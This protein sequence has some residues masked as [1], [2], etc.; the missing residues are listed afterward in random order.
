MKNKFNLCFRIP[1]FVFLILFL[2]GC[3]N[4]KSEITHG[5]I[6][7]DDIG[8]Q[9]SIQKVPHK[10]V[11]LAPN[12]TEIIF[13]LHAENQ[14]S[15]VSDYCNYPEGVKQKTKIGGIINPNLEAIVTL[16]PDLVFA[17]A[18]GN[19]KPTVEK[20]N[21]LNIPVFTFNTNNMSQLFECI[22]TIG[23]I[24]DHSKEADSIVFSMIQ[25]LTH[26]NKIEKQ[27][28]VF[29]VLNRVPII[30]VS[31]GSF[32]NEILNLAGGRNA[33]PEM[34][35]RYPT[36]NREEVLNLNPDFIVI[37]EKEY[38]PLPEKEYSDFE[39]IATV[40]AYKNKKIY[41]VNPDLILRPGPRLV[42]GI[43][44]LNTILSQ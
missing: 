36:I 33:V 20:L 43:I 24:T 42:Q 22:K 14:L 1:I 19:P 30:S 11:S 15:G 17:T 38:Q 25:S 10:I 6:F 44:Q 18:D 27:P 3:N 31:S 41:Y 2:F 37:P 7:T 5:I 26:L 9:I 32:L 34:K 35:E 29:L 12:I 4:Q 23:K 21:A 39:S 16:Q 8:T 40:S 13:A 28:S